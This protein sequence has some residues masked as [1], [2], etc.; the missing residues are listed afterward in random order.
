MILTPL[1]SPAKDLQM[2][3]SRLLLQNVGAKTYPV[4]E[5]WVD[6]RDHSL[7]IVVC[8][9]SYQNYSMRLVKTAKSMNQL[10]CGFAKDSLWMSSNQGIPR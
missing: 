6:N 3:G 1:R 4:A 5:E 10:G 2:F 9:N 7:N 8:K